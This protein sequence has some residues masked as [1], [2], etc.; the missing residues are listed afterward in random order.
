MEITGFNKVEASS[1]K[2][3]P[4]LVCSGSLWSSWR[5]LFRYTLPLYW[6]VQDSASKARNATEHLCFTILFWRPWDPEPLLTPEM[7]AWLPSVQ[8]VHIPLTILPFWLSG[9]SNLTMS[10]SIAA[11]PNK[12]GMMS[13]FSSSNSLYFLKYFTPRLYA[14]RTSAGDLWV[15]TWSTSLITLDESWNIGSK[16]IRFLE[17]ST[18]R[19]NPTIVME[20]PL[21]RL[22][23]QSTRI[24][25]IITS[26]LKI[27]RR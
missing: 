15:K 14:R 8:K 1:F 23:M 26:M 10:I 5:V 2:W 6:V 25:M 9:G 13:Y 16:T 7:L 27:Q 3:V 24:D 19:S 4:M 11:R 17:P 21:L 18:F 20:W 22:A 12:D